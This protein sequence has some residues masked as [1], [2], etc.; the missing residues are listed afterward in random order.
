MIAY[1]VIRKVKN[2]SYITNLIDRFK[3]SVIKSIYTKIEKWYNNYAV[4]DKQIMG[5]FVLANNYYG[6][7]DIIDDIV[8]ML[9]ERGDKDMML[10]AI[11]KL[12]S[13]GKEC[14]RNR[15]REKALALFDN[16]KCYQNYL[17]LYNDLLGN[18]Q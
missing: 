8:G 5:D 16:Q 7:A 2:M 18:T 1:Y 9:V 3:I 17:H 15:C 11:Q 13:I 10:S 4:G 14:Y 6:S 12:R